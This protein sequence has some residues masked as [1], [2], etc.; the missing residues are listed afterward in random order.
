[1]IVITGAAGFIGSCLAGKL[2]REGHGDL[3]LVDDFASHEKMKNLAGKQFRKQV[4]RE[5]FFEWF[6]QNHHHVSFVFHLGARTNTAE[7]NKAIFDRLNLQY[8][9]SVWEACTVYGVPLVYASSAATY[10][11]G[12]HGYADNHELIAQLKPLNPYGKSKHSFDKWALQQAT[13]PPYWAGLKFFNVYGPNE[14]HK[15]RMASAILHLFREADTR[16]EVSLF[17]SHR[18]NIAHGEQ[19]RDFIYSKDVVNVCYFMMTQQPAPGIYN[20]GTG[21]ASSFLE[22]AEAIFEAIGKKSQ[23]N[24]IDTPENIRDNY[25][26]YTQAS[27][28]KLLLAGYSEKFY[29]LKEGIYDYINHYLKR[30]AYY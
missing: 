12:E 15:K 22:L 24:F 18:E 5:A 25:Q 21:R 29:S 20:L 23:I 6:K 2:N 30:S 26:Y 7:Q 4:N 3:V 28:D 10:G 19:R 27:M 11:A 9:K 1:M 14:Y 16:G 8:S 17:R 13:Q